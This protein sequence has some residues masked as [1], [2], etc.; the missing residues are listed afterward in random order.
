MVAFPDDGSSRVDSIRVRVVLP[1]PFLPI[2]A[3]MPF[4]GIEKSTEVRAFLPVLN[5]LPMSLQTISPS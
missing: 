4:A 5:T 3:K 1:A 2:S